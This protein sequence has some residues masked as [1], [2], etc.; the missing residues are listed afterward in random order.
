MAHNGLARTIFPVHTMYDGDTLFCL[1]TGEA[2][3]DVSLAG[4]AAAIAVENAVLRAVQ[5]LRPS[6]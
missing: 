3:I 4:M 2:E 1:A 6:L 5:A